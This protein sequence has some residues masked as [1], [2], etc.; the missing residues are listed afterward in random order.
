MGPSRL[1]LLA[2]AGLARAKA[3]RA[4]LTAAAVRPLHPTARPGN[5]ELDG[6]VYLD[7]ERRTNPD[8][9]PAWTVNNVH[10]G[11]LGAGCAVLASR[12]WAGGGASWRGPAVHAPPAPPKGARCS[13]A[14]ACARRAPAPCRPVPHLHQG[15]REPP[16]GAHPLALSTSL[17]SRCIPVGPPGTCIHPPFPPAC[18]RLCSR[19]CH[20]A[21]QLCHRG[22]V[23]ARQTAGLCNESQ[24]IDG[25]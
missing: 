7:L 19:S 21:A 24:L 1:L 3:L 22:T 15:G 25:G 8:G 11:G 9:T 23:A 5:K 4:W 10:Y 2:A 12:G 20:S 6:P 14:H 18:A 16:P 13:K 17:A